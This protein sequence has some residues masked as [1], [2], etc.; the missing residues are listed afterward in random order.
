M[1]TITA[2]LVSSAAAYLP[3]MIFGDSLSQSQ[4]IISS[5]IIGTITYALTLWYMKR[6]RD[7]V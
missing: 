2:L 7:G 1:P 5:L 4:E 3:V 6:L